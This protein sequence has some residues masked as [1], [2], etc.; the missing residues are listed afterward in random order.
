MP[1]IGPVSSMTEP[2]DQR[3]TILTK[4][5]EGGSVI[6]KVTALYTQHSSPTKSY[7][8]TIVMAT[9]FSVEHALSSLQSYTTS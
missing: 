3:G 7:V 8:R 2:V 5:V 6:W 1:G 9:L 4:G